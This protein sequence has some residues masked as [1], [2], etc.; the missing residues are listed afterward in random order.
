MT[1]ARR[2]SPGDWALYAILAVA[3]VPFVLPLAWMV[4]VSLKG[5]N[6]VF[7]F[8]PDL[9]PDAPRWQ[10]YRDVFANAPFARQYWNSSY[11]AVATVALTLVVAVM[12][13]FAFARLRFP[14]RDALFVVMLTGLFLPVETVIIPLFI[15]MDA[16][17]LTGTHWP[18][19]L[20][21]VF[22][23][24]AIVGTFIMRQAF[25]SLPKELEEAGRVDG[26]SW[27]GI[28][29]WVAVPLSWPSIATVALL[30]F[31]ASWNMFLEPL[32]FTGG[33]ADRWTVPVGLDQ[34]TDFQGVPFWTLQMAATT[35]A[36]L[37]FVVLFL[38]LQRQITRG[39]ATSGLK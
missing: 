17:G 28:L 14:G 15:L 13:G 18:L 24:P 27:L 10:N 21:P 9:I 26:M 22:G 29:W 34:F 3:A 39:I 4:S 35:L 31:L 12:S 19:I 1:S 5:E 38:L 2:L 20:E 6:E 36:V 16:L 33:S 25:L 23:A 7:A 37:P 32:V 11:I 30:T 8:P